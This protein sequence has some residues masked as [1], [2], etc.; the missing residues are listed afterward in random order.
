MDKDRI[1]GSVSILSALSSDSS[2]A[3][4]R[5]RA[6]KDEPQMTSKLDRLSVDS[7]SPT[8]HDPADEDRP[9]AVLT[10]QEA[11][12]GETSGHMRFV[13]AGSLI[14]MIIAGVIFYAFAL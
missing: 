7:W 1:A 12:Q 10:T 13:L 11:R 3:S 4:P 5:G 6:E 14:L 2:F 8:D 9:G